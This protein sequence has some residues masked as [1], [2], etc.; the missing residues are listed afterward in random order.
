MLLQL[1]QDQS[2]IQF[3]SF[4]FIDL[5]CWNSDRGNCFFYGRDQPKSS[6]WQSG[7][8]SS[9]IDSFYIDNGRIFFH[10]SAWIGGYKNQNDNAMILLIFLNSLNEQVGSNITLGPVLAVHRHNVTSLLYQQTSGLVPI[11]T[12]TFLIKILMTYFSGG[13]NDGSIDNIILDFY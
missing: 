4:H 6:M 2:L 9:K 7:N 1:I 13:L 12:R 10:L 11:G 3:N 5:F 8:L